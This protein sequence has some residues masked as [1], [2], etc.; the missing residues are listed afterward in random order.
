L[1]TRVIAHHD[2]RHA[3]EPAELIVDDPSLARAFATLKDPDREALCLV[4]WEGLSNDE[5][6]R[7]AGCSTAT[8]AVR[9]SRARTRLGAALEL[10]RAAHRQPEG[11][12]HRSPCPQTDPV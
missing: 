3:P 5:A 4:A 6:A 12:V 1:V 11:H 7:A 8:F 10:E 9:Y 2:R